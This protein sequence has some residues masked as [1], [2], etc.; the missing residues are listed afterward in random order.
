MKRLLNIGE[1]NSKR[2]L[3]IICLVLG[4]FVPGCIPTEHLFDALLGKDCQ[5]QRPNP[6]SR[7]VVTY[8]TRG[9]QQK[10]FE[11]AVCPPI[12]PGVFSSDCGDPKTLPVDDCVEVIRISCSE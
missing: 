5:F 11:V 1:R 12:I 2:I 10:D 3:S 9:G 8:R 7:C 6:S 4:L